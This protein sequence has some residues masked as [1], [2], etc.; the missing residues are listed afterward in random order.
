MMFLLLDV[1][2]QRAFPFTSVVI[3]HERPDLTSAGSAI[4]MIDH[5][6]ETPQTSDACYLRRFAENLKTPGAAES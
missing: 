3:G 5:Y 1:K 6:M 4:L 2:R